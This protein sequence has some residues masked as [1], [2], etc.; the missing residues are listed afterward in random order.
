M[1][2]DY[3]D[4]FNETPKGDI[5]QIE[6]TDIPDHDVLAAGFPCQPFSI[7]GVSKK[8]SLGH[9]HGFKCD[10]QGN[11]FFYLATVAAMK[12]PPVLFLE[13][14]K[15]LQ[16]H[17]KGRTWQVIF[18]TLESLEYRVFD[19]VIDAASYV[20][21]H[22]E[23]LHRLLRGRVFGHSPPFRFR[24]RRRGPSRYATSSV[25]S[26]SAFQPTEEPPGT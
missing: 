11:L 26:G 12:R 10:T 6:P 21:Q 18:D 3:R 1:V 13:N 2:S 17:D 19:R 14:V 22:R 23:R 25:Q 24:L 7:A 5:T 20:P 16:S 15:N 8:K 4:W 9:A